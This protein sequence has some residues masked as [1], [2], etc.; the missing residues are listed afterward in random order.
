ME[1]V[2]T[3]LRAE[4]EGVLGVELRCPSRAAL[5]GFEPGAHVDVALPNGLTTQYS[6]ASS[7]ADAM[8][9]T[10]EK[11]AILGRMSCIRGGL[12]FF[13]QMPLK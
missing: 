5:P 11:R 4:A 10:C 7:A 2:V 3:G 6:I 12:R 13:G 8:S 9:K 1:L